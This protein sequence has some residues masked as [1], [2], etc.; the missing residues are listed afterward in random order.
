MEE[1][2]FC[3]KCDI[4]LSLENC[5]PSFW[6]R[7]FKICRKCSMNQDKKRVKKYRV[8]I[9]EK[10]GNKCECCG[11]TKFSFLSIDHIFGNGQNDRKNYKNYKYYI[12]RLY[13]MPLEELKSKYRCLCF[14]CNY[15]MG[16]WNTCPHKWVT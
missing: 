15:A 16:F 7:K 8:L 11:I 2:I 13:N 5:F 1:Q 14:N 10:L 12:T 6:K 3:R 9:L 4:I